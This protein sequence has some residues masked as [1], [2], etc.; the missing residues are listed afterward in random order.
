MYSCSATWLALTSISRLRPAAFTTPISKE[1]ALISSNNWLFLKIQLFY[2]VFRPEGHRTYPQGGS[3]S[4]N[5]KNNSCFVEWYGNSGMQQGRRQGGPGA[6]APPD[7]GGSVNPHSTRGDTLS[8]PSTTCPPG[9]LTLA[10]C[11]ELIGYHWKILV[12]CWQILLSLSQSSQTTA[13]SLIDIKN[14]QFSCQ[15][16]SCTLTKTLNGADKNSEPF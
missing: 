10:A 5:M 7:F 1:I 11:L 3:C 15:S 4:W 14:F 9:F 2:L 16:W 8:P 12:N 6:A 13:I